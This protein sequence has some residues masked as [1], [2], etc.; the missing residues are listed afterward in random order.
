MKRSMTRSLA[1]LLALCMMLALTA[2]GQKAPAAETQPQTEAAPAAEAQPGT[3][4]ASSEAETAPTP[5]GD[6][7]WLKLA[8]SFAYPS[9]DAHKDYYGWYTSIYGVTE[10]L[11]RVADDLSVQPLL[12]KDY[13]VSEDG[14]TWTVRLADAVFSNGTPVT[15]DMVMR[16]FRRLAEKNERFAYLSD[17]AFAAPDEKT[18]TITTPEIYPTMLSD[19][20]APE[21]AVMD[22]DGTTDFDNAP[23]RHRSL[24]R[25]VLYARGYRRGR[26]ERSLLEWQRQ[27]GRR[28]LLLYAGR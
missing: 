9:L 28:D 19:L 22:L 3:E 27:A 26:E 14:K 18:L 15:A 8:E 25:E 13:T 1:V 20:S 21:L 24:C 7:K 11:F 16:N 23:R 12:A 2:C 6:A 5:A 17:F 10:T 4:T